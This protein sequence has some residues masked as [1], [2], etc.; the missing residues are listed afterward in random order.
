MLPPAQIKPHHPRWKSFTVG[1]KLAAIF[2]VFFL[3]S[4]SSLVLVVTLYNGIAGV[5]R[6]V[7]ES[8]KLRYLSQRL[9]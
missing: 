1:Q 2:F 4:A 7:N 9:A 3:F 8:G 5:S 6:L